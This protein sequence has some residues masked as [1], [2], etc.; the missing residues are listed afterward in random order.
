MKKGNKLQLKDKRK[1]EKKIKIE[2]E[3]NQQKDL[4]LK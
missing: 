1:R 3:G 2:I 4:G